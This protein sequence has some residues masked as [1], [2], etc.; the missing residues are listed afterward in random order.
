MDEI[1][2]G[3]I[4]QHDTPLSLEEIAQAVHA[5]R[6]IIIEMVEYHLLEPKGKS[7]SNWEFDDVCLRRAKTAVSF[8]QDL[9]INMPGVAMVIDLLER[10]EVLEQRLRTLERFEEE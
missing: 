5:E 7:P 1:I 9:E 2:K 8:Y 4:I 10:I 3:I 6:R